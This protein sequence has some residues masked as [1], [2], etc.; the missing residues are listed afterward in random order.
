MGVKGVHMAQG[1]QQWVPHGSPYGDEHNEVLLSWSKG[2]GN[3][4]CSFSNGV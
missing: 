1:S 4:T 2:F 3:V